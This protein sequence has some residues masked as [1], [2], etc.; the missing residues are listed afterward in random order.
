MIHFLFRNTDP[1]IAEELHR[2]RKLIYAGLIFSALAAL[3]AGAVTVSI[4]FVVDAVGSQDPQKLIWLSFLILGL[5]VLKYFFVQGQVLKIGEAANRLTAS[6]RKRLFEK[7]MRLPVSYY[8]RQRAGALQSILTNDVTIFQSAL[9]AVRDSIDGP[10]KVTIGLITIFVLQ[11][12]LALVSILVLPLIAHLIRRNGQKMRVTQEEAQVDLAEMT[13]MMQESVQG[14]KIIQAFGAEQATSHRFEASVERSFGSQMKVTRRVGRLKPLVEL[15]GAFGIAMVVLMCA[16]LVQRRALTVGDLG[17]FLFALDGINQGF[18]NLGSLKQTMGQVEAASKR[19][20]SEILDAPEPL[21]D[22]ADA[23]SLVTFAGRV[24][25]RNVG[26]QYPDGTTAVRGVSFVIEPG[27]SLALVG[28]SGAGKST[29]ADLLLRFYD[30]TEGQILFDG[31]DVRELKLDWL[32]SQISVVPQ[33]TFLFSGSIAENLRMSAPE[34]SDAELL[35]ALD[36][37]HAGFV[38]NLPHGPLTALGE[39]GV[40]VSGGEAQR[41]AIARA[42]LRKPKVLVL[43]EATSN[44]DAESEKAVSEALVG[45]MGQCSTLLIAHRLSTAARA[46]K[47]LMLR[48][49]EILEQGTFAE[50]TANGGA[51]SQLYDAYRAGLVPEVL[52]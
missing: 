51:F 12:Q 35:T 21:A 38:Q 20:Y 50:L 13:A 3:V 41:L 28:P 23:R 52:Q 29:L 19:I 36:A 27:Q 7:L 15:V 43:D 11:W 1:R 16:W 25:F 18:R 22:L 2:Q 17:A 14:A 32:R 24:E 33:Q 40:G 44:L 31:V 39:R 46:D 47:I 37:A 9:T 26:F 30:P 8:H 49:G 10:I 48:G 34:A 42:I 4:K 5:Y 45:I 6:L